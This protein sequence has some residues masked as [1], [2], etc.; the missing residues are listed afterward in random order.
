MRS[1]GA[2][3]SHE[4][5]VALAFVAIS[6]VA[7]LALGAM[8]IDLSMLMDARAEAQRA[9]DAA[10]LAGADAFRKLPGQPLATPEARKNAFEVA[11]KNTVYGKAVD[12]MGAKA[13]VVKNFGWGSVTTYEANELTVQVIRGAAPGVGDSNRVRVWVKPAE[14]PTFFART[15]NIGTRAVQAMATAHASPDAPEINCM[16]PFMLSDM[17]FENNKTTQDNNTA[18]GILDAAAASKDGGEQWF[19]EP[20]AGDTYVRYGEGTPCSGYGCGRGEYANDWGTPLMI[21]PQQGNAQRQGNWYFTLDGPE[22]NLRAQ[23]EAGCIDAGVGDVPEA[24]QGGKTGQV[25]QGTNT[26]I[27]QDPSAHWDPASKTIVGSDPKFGDWTKSPRTIIV[28]LFDP[29]YMAGVAGKNEKIPPGVVYDNFVRV[30]LEQVDK[31]DNIM[32]RFLGFA[33][34]G[35]TGSETGSIVL[36]LQLIQ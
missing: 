31:N 24:E 4:R 20:A 28:G 1:P 30:W 13:G 34:G 29:K 33:P 18:N 7:L 19:Y 23:I 15:L 5:G 6:L 27:A 9:A 8:A 10:A 17:W 22:Q 35:G 21:K 14:I 3:R 26:L 11:A 25:T 32:V 2:A 16:K 36:K 12:T